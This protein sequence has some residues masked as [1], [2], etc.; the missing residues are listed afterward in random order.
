[1]WVYRV[2]K[3]CERVYKGVSDKLKKRELNTLEGRKQVADSS[4]LH[5]AV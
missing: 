5:V 2:V 4:M 3:G 1:M